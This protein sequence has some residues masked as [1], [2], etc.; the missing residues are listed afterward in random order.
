MS[1][2]AAGRLW[3]A[4]TSASTWRGWGLGHILASPYHSQTCGKVG[5]YHLSCKEQVNLVAWE[6]PG[7]LE[8]EIARFVAWYN[9]ERYHEAPSEARNFPCQSEHCSKN[10]A[11]LVRNMVTM[12]GMVITVRPCVTRA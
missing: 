12:V 11:N 7:Q 10:V 5:R 8:A 2:R 6:I 4:G 3:R 1:T 9:T